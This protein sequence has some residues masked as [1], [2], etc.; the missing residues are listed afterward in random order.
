MQL[1]LSERRTQL[2][3]VAADRPGDVWSL[4]AAETRRSLRLCGPGLVG[5]SAGEELERGLCLRL[6]VG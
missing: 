2:G 6:R 5:Q 1:R 3:P 4:S